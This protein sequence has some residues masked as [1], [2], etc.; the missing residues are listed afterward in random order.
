M[1]RIEVRSISPGRDPR[2]DAYVRRQPPAQS[3]HLAAWQE[4]IERVSRGRGRHLA[5]FDGDE[6]RG[7]LPLVLRH[8]VVSGRRLR[9]LPGV[10]AG[11]VADDVHGAAALL[12]AARDVAEREG[13]T[14]AIN[15]R[16]TGI[17]EA[18]AGVGIISGPPTWILSLRTPP[19]E[20]RASWKRSSNL[21]RSLRKAEAAGMHVRLS[22][23]GADL[24]AFHG[25]Y[26]R[27]MHK[28]ATL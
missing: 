12:R 1:H 20:L 26:V 25:L 7:I 2:W 17:D 14:L 13:A 21:A 24:R 19:E 5:L 9:S 16:M 23:S 27:T 15:G 18:Q 6:L 8:G 10:T 11:P 22:T 3:I 28:H 4:V